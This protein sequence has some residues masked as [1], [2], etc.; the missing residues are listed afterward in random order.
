MFQCFEGFDLLHFRSGAP[1]QA[2]VLGLKALHQ[3]VLRLFG[4]ALHNSILSPYTACSILP[5]RNFEERDSLRIRA[6]L[7]LV[8]PNMYTHETF[9]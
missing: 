2:Q 1:Q 5:R 3:Q 8:L 7:A 6:A 4:P 9:M